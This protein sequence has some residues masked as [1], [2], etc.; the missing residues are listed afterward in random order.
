MSYFAHFL[1]ILLKTNQQSSDRKDKI[2]CLERNCDWKAKQA[3]KSVSKTFL[4]RDYQRHRGEPLMYSWILQ[5]KKCCHSGKTN[6]PSLL[7][8]MLHHAIL[9]H[10][11]HYNA[12]LIHHANHPKLSEAEPSIDFRHWIRVHRPSFHLCARSC[13]LWVF[14]WAPILSAPTLSS[15]LPPPPPLIRQSTRDCVIPSPSPAR[16]GWG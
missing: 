13:F 15:L 11:T 2:N 3:K 10:V 1:I 5:T 8:S 12:P 4:K 16:L 14:K 7:F 6:Y 9:S